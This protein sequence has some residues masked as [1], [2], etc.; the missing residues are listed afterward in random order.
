M[1]IDR[2]TFGII[3]MEALS[4][5]KLSPYTQVSVMLAL[6]TIKKP[7]TEKVE[8][9]A[10]E[11]QKAIDDL[12]KGIMRPAFARTNSYSPCYEVV[13]SLGIADSK[14]VVKVLN[15]IS[16]LAKSRKKGHHYYA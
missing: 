5:S 2:E 9:F 14:E 1:K 16:I 3:T 4:V 7:S 6:D 12:E 11:W 13:E 15:N 10:R 8:F